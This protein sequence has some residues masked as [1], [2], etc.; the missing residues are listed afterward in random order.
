MIQM[1]DKVQSA[2][3]FLSDPSTLNSSLESKVQFL[4]SKGLSGAEIN[5]ALGA[6]NSNRRMQYT[7]P[8][9]YELQRDWRD[10]FVSLGCGL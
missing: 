5:Q 10:Y 8:Q 1:A 3:E 2:I 4:E 7:Q 6:A 9:R